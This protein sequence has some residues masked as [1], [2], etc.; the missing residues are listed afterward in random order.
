MLPLLP[1]LLLPLSY[2]LKIDIRLSSIHICRR[3][4]RARPTAAIN[5]Q[6]QH[7]DQPFIRSGA[8]LMHL[9][10][11][12]GVATLVAAASAVEMQYFDSPRGGGPIHYSR[13]TNSNSN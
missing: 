10:K 8:S 11:S 4:R 9:L 13:H 1:P 5:Q 6:N 2:S 3:V 12:V 7:A